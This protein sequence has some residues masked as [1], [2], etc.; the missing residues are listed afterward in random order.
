MHRNGF[1]A[2]ITHLWIL[3]KTSTVSE[4][5]AVLEELECIRPASC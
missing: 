2:K 5:S 1:C 3:C 4:A